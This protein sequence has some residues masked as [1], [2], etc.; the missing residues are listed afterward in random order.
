MSELV[1]VPALA[2]RREFLLTL[3]CGPLLAGLLG[4]CSVPRRSAAGLAQESGWLTQ[5]FRDRDAVARFGN[6]YLQAHPAERRADA[7]SAAIH[8]ALLRR[9]PG[10]LDAADPATAFRT[11]DAVVRDEYRRGQV[12]SVDG[13]LLSQTEA[14]VY[15]VVALQQPGG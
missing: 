9:Q 4:A 3:M 10:A 2:T 7:L 13:W 5:L 6:A 15:A 1:P 8:E 14:R 11:L 12:T